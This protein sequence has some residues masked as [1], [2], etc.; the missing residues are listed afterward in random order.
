MRRFEPAAAG[1]GDCA[2]PLPSLLFRGATPAGERLNRRCPRFAERRHA[3]TRFRI[4]VSPR[5]RAMAPPSAVS[6]ASRSTIISGMNELSKD[7]VNWLTVGEEAAGQRIDNFLVRVLK[8]VPKSHVYRI[9]R[10]GEVRVNKR[11]GRRRTRGL[12]AAMSCA[13]RPIR[14]AAPRSIERRVAGRSAQS[15]ILFEDDALARARQA[16]R[17]RRPRRQRHRARA[18]RAAARGAP[19]RAVPRA[20][21][22]AR[23]RHVG[24]AAGREEARGAG[25]AARAAARRRSRQALSRAGAR[26]LARREARGRACR[27]TSSRR[28]KA[29]GGCGSRAEGAARG[30]DLSAAEY[31]AR[32]AIRRSRCSKPSSRP[33]ARIRSAFIWRI[34]AFR[35]RATTSTATSRGTRRLKRQGLKRMF[36]HASRL[37]FAHPDSGERV[38]FDFR[39][40]AGAAIVRRSARRGRRWQRPCGQSCIARCTDVTT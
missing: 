1:C 38:R 22:S 16:G 4:G 34:S 13:C 3:R 7:A 18:D 24:R 26:A 8:G 27:C 33:G 37:A 14:S 31:V 36:L 17:T 21:A 15:P 9:L 28:G 6:G 40:G 2:L 23:S 11:A 10:S 32:S 12:R 35:S 30:N 5:D 20:R 29:S 39:V 25:R 19:G